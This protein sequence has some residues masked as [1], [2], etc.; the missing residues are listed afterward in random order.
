MRCDIIC[1]GDIMDKF[2]F[3]KGEKLRKQLEF[4]IIID[5]MKN[6]FRR[7]LIKDGSRCEND[8]EHSWHLA[9]LAMIL[10]EYSAEKSTLKKC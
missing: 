4:I 9:V 7:N 10:E 5:E 6:V 1:S 2:D 3:V 8:A